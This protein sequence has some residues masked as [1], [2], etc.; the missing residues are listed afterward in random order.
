VLS[1]VPLESN[2]MKGSPFWEMIVR[3]LFIKHFAVRINK[4]LWL[5]ASPWIL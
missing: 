1:H 2:Y 4:L 3:G 5:M